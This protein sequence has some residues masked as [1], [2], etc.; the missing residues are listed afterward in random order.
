MSNWVTRLFSLAALVLLHST[1]SGPLPA[2]PEIQSGVARSI[3]ALHNRPWTYSLTGSVWA[4]CVIGCMAQPHTRS[5]F[6]NLMSD[7]VRE[8]GRI[9]NSATVLKIIR[10]C[11]QLQETGRADSRITMREMGI[12]AILI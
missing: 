4:L 11:W 7:M 8:S 5:F 10:K 12:R 3:V 9:G 6:E 1:V 2:L